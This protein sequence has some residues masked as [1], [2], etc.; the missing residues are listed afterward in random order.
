GGGQLVGLLVLVAP[1]GEQDGV[2]GRGRRRGEEGAGEVEPGADG[3]AARRLR[4]GDRRLGAL[5]V[6]GGRRGEAAPVD[7][8][9]EPGLVVA[10]DD[11]EGHAVVQAVDGGRRGL[12][13]RLQLAGR[14]HRPA[15]VEDDHLGP[16]GAAPDRGR[17]R[18]LLV[19]RGL[20]GHDRVDGV[21]PGG[22]V[23]VLV[24]LGGEGARGTG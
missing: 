1:V 8:P 11:G 2:A 3:G 21:G 20:H 19:P 6:G 5:P 7:G 15:G 22:Q 12:L 10:G 16:V 18:R 23:L 14:A 17:A 9:D 13:G 24:R 4:G